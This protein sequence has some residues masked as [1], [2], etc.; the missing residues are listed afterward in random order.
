MGQTKEA[1]NHSRAAGVPIMVAIN[2]TDKQGADPDRVKRELAEMELVPEDWGGDT[3][4]VDV[5]A[6]TGQGV[7]TLLEMLELQ[8]ELMELT[9]N[10]TKP[11]RGHIL[12][13]RLDKGRGPVATVL[14]QEGTLRTGAPFVCGVY[15]GKVRAM[16]DD[17]G[18]RVEEAAPSIP[19][20]V[21]GLGGVPEAGDDFAVVESDKDARQIAEHRAQK[22]REAELSQAKGVSLEGFFDQMREGEVQELKLVIKADV[23]GSVEAVVEAV[24]KLGNEQVKVDV[25]HSATGAITESDV[26]LAAASNAII[27]GFNVRPAGKVNET[28]EQERVDIRTYEVIYQILDDVTAALTGMLAPVL[29][30]DVIGRVEV[31]DT[32]GVPKVGTVAGCYVTSGKVERGAQARLLRD[33]AVVTTARISSL[34]RFKEDVKEVAQGYECGM[35]LENYNDIKIGD[36]IEIFVTR[37]VAPEL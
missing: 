27:I 18:Q 1:I 14:V 24:G 15:A 20:E 4:M 36:E 16:F 10:P 37:E 22:K 9:A 26:M 12:E 19:V 34:R 21:Q 33:G 32:F 7:D 35:G 29:E 30:E 3:I 8:S 25:I 11:A 31:R 2:K 6:K 13:A 28:A 23:Q 5:S 17:M